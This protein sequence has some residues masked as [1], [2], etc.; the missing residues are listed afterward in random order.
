MAFVKVATVQEVPPGSAKQVTVNGRPVGLFNVGGAFYAIED[1][2]PHR[3]AALSEGVCE[4]TEVICPWHGA[5]FDLTT[6]SHLSP[7]ATR[8]VTA[9]KVQVVGDEI[10]LDV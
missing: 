5:S 1:V 6:G 10:R 8:G 9:F 7:P 3:G 4:G 2:C